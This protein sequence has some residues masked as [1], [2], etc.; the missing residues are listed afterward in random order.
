MIFYQWNFLVMENIWITTAA[1]AQEHYGNEK[2]QSGF[3][4]FIKFCSIKLTIFRLM[5]QL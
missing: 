4:N 3:I 2:A 5:R 1:K